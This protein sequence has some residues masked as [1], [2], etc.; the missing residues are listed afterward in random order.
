MQI[1]GGF[2]RKNIE[3]CAHACKYQKK[4][5]PLQHFLCAKPVFLRGSLNFEHFVTIF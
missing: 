3:K 5:V 4:A 2:L 1:I